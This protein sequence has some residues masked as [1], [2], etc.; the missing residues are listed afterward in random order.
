M[1]GLDG[2]GVLSIAM[3]RPGFYFAGTT[4]AGIYS[5]DTARATLTV[6]ENQLSGLRL[7]AFPNPSLQ[8]VRID[9]Q[10]PHTGYVEIG[11][12]NPLGES[13]EDIYNQEVTSG[14]HE[15]TFEHKSLPPGLY[16]LRAIFGGSS[17]TIALDFQQ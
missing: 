7:S 9:F 8:S 10:S 15:I 5:T 1:D 13:I 6:V 11:L 12:F 3:A 17:T 2:M 16:Y 4:L 14:N